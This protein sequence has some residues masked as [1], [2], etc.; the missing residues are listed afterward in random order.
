MFITTYAVI[1]MASGAVLEQAGYD[2]AGPVAECKKGG[3]APSPDPAIGQA[4]MEN[5]KLGKDWLAFSRQEWE[6]QQPRQAEIDTYSRNF[7]DQQLADSKF[8]SERA[9]EQWSDY[10]STFRPIEQQVAKEAMQYDSAGRQASESAASVATVGKQFDNALAAQARSN[11]RMGVNPN[12][13]RAGAAMNDLLLNRALATS[14]AETNT[15]RDVMK[16]GLM[17]RKDAASL[18]RGLPGTATQTFSVGTGMGTSGQGALQGAASQVSNNNAIMG[19]GFSGAMGGNTSAM[20]GLSQQYQNQLAAWQMNQAGSN[21][22]MGMI[23]NIGGA[24][25]GNGFKFGGK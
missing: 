12:S 1:D 24:W 19:Q 14:A 7:A 25:A 13:G 18:G 6:A 3:K 10:T 2:Y 9:R 15:R 20:N 8:N 5:A 17:L 21:G 11:G 4:A 16:T 22:L 23:G